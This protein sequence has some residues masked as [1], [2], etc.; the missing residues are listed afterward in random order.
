MD[1]L[2]EIQEQ[3]REDSA[4]WFPSTSD[5]LAFMVLAL[6]GEVGELAN[7]T[8][9]VIRGSLNLTDEDVQQALAG[10]VVDVLTYL[11]NVANLLGISL[12]A[13]YSAK[14]DFNEQRFG[15]VTPIGPVG[16]DRSGDSGTVE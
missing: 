12:S 3:C 11:A 16:Y 2:K 10:E 8:K 4:R 9:K 6:S 14:R 13:G 7:I 1:S 15:N 5:S